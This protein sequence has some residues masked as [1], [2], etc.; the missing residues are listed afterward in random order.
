MVRQRIVFARVPRRK[1]PQVG[2]ARAIR[3]ARTDAGL[4]P[5]ALAERLG[6]DLSE[7]SRLENGKG[8]PQWGTVRRVADALDLTL[9][10]LAALAED[11]DRRL[12]EEPP[13]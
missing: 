13:A 2:V 4:E 10:E 11:F 9:P 8:N 3:K 1:D 5:K 7:V 6:V 12:S